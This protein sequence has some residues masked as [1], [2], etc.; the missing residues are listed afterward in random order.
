MRH[1]PACPISYST[2]IESPDGRHGLVLEVAEG[3]YLC[4]EC[5]RECHCTAVVKTRVAVA[6]A[7]KKVLPPSRTRDDAVA[8]ATFA[9]TEHWTEQS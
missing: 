5:L 7:L 9:T 6:D 1:D 4:D 8:I 3:Y 2:C